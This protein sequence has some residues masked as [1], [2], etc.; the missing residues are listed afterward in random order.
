[1][2]TEEANTSA[3]SFVDGDLLMVTCS[4]NTVKNQIVGNLLDAE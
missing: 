1:V 3:A 4:Q 2:E